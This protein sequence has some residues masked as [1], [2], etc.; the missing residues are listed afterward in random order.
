M[1]KQSKMREYKINLMSPTLC[2]HTCE[3]VRRD[4]INIPSVDVSRYFVE[5]F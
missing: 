1:Y 4:E 3:H 2:V 5:F